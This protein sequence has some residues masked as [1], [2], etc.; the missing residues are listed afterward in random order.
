MKRAVLDLRLTLDQTTANQER[1]LREIAPQG[2]E[3]VK[4][5]KD[6][7]AKAGRSTDSGASIA[8]VRAARASCC[9]PAPTGLDTRTPAGK[10]M[11][12]MM[13]VFAEFERAIVQERRPGL[14]APKARARARTPSDSPGDGRAHQEGSGDSWKARRAC[15]CQAVRY[16]SG[17]GAAD[18]PPFRR[19]RKRGR[20]VARPPLR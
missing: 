17:H 4:V 13:G 1:E 5:Y 20:R 3:I 12:Q 15:H 14:S 2:C 8:F 7:A 6:D 10:A 11:F 19:R 16:R 18:Q 9:I